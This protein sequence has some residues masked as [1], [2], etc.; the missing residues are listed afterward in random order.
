[1]FYIFFLSFI[2]KVVVKYRKIETAFIDMD[3]GALFFN[4]KYQNQSYGWT[5]GTLLTQWQAT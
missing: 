5:S 4:G 2:F 1:M 3:T